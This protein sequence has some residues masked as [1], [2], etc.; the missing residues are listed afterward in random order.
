MG[1][2]LD[3]FGLTANKIDISPLR[4]DRQLIEFDLFEC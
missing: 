3:Y 4:G 1:I 2:S